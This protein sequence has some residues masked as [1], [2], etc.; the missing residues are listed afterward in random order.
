MFFVRSSEIWATHFLFTDN[1]M[2]IKMNEEI[3]LTH[4]QNETQETH[5]EQENKVCPNCGEELLSDSVF[6]VK[7]G[8]KIEENQTTPEN[9]SKI[10]FL[11]KHK[12]KI[13]SIVGAIVA[14]FLIVFIVNSIQAA[15]LKKQLLRGWENVEGEK[16][17]YI[18]CVLDFSDDEI[19]YRVET[20]YKWMDTTIATYD[21]KV[22]SG[23]K[24]KVN[25][26][27]NDWETI[28]IEFNDDKTMMT[29]T[30]ALTSV[31]DEE[32]WFHID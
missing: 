17:S 7:C 31:D 12:K 25:R 5:E 9:D 10:S 11:A 14:V 16:G 21:Y 30:P 27:G 13:F 20:G 15:N 2:G 23:N 28:E 4:E 18:I 1:V 26:F 22:V 6:C 24:I 3:L 8:T 19:E 29:V 32:Q